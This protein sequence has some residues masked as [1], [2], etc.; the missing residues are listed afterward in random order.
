MLLVQESMRPTDP[1]PAP[2]PSPQSRGVGGYHNHPNS[3]LSPTEA[4]AALS[5]LSLPWQPHIDQRQASTSTHHLAPRSTSPITPDPRPAASTSASS[6]IPGPSS[7]SSANL[8]ARPGH[9][10]GTKRPNS[11]S[12]IS[13]G[14]TAKTT[15]TTSG[16]KRQKRSTAVSTA[17]AGC[18][19]RKSRCD[20]AT[21]SC[22]TCL[23]HKE[24]CTYSAGDGRKPPSKEYVQS[25]QERIR[26]L[27]RALEEQTQQSCSGATPSDLSTN[28]PDSLCSG[29]G[30][31]ARPQ[32]HGGRF[33][34]VRGNQVVAY[35][36]TSSY[37]RRL[38][39]SLCPHPPMPDGGCRMMLTYNASRP[40]TLRRRQ[41]RQRTAN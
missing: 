31:A 18:R 16:P 35:G 10:S 4:A 13:D 15:P 41:H 38:H 19:R 9:I 26:A 36:P 39:F 29:E 28:A 11:S 2:N 32:N 22:S 21:P 3:Q 1:T 12:H 8:H 34:V 30:R 6:S 17:C 37:V 33:K 20:G 24:E 5:D 7:T 14:D 23:A 25:L 40:A 27:E